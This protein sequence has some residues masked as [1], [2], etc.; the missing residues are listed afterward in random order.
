MIDT[1]RRFMP[2]ALTAAICLPQAAL[3]QSPLV[4]PSDDGGYLQWIVAAGLAV[5]VLA[6]AFLNPKRSHLS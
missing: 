2:A 6:A 3:A 5:I 4:V 1:K